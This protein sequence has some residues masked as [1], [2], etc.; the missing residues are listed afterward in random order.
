MLGYSLTTE[1][2]L[3]IPNMPV[4]NFWQKLMTLR[5]E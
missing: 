1:V 3:R 5:K 2:R 4:P